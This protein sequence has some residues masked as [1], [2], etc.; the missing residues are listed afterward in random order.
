[1]SDNNGL[2]RPV[3]P[4]QEAVLY[5]DVL[6]YWRDLTLSL[7]SQL[8]VEKAKL[9][10]RDREIEVLKAQLQDNNKKAMERGHSVGTPKE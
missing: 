6:E 8:S 5:D 2:P 4:Q 10:N 7:H 1:M 9:R 3:D